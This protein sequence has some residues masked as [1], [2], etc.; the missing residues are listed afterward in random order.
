MVTAFKRNIMWSNRYWLLQLPLHR[1]Q[2]GLVQIFYRSLI[3]AV[4][5]QRLRSAPDLMLVYIIILENCSSARVILKYSN[6]EFIN[7]LG[8]RSWLL[9]FIVILRFF[10]LRF[11]IILAILKWILVS[12][13]F[14][15]NLDHLLWLVELSVE[16]LATRSK[17]QIF[18]LKIDG[19]LLV[20]FKALFR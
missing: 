5:W 3:Q 2:Q 1:R 14:V 16:F 4:R 10:N 7:L 18:F 15:F 8:R 19:V 20:D 17:S 6:S 12:L 13:W 9:Y 11:L